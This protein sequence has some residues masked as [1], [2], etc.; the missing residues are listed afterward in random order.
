MFIFFI[1]MYLY[2]KN[3]HVF[4]RSIFFFKKKMIV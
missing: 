1:Y 2:E 4:Q 3:F